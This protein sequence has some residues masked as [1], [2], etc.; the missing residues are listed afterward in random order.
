MLLKLDS[1]RS[2]RRLRIRTSCFTFTDQRVSIPAPIYLALFSPLEISSIHELLRSRLLRSS[3]RYSRFVY[4]LS[5]GDSL[6][7]LG[8]NPTRRDATRC[9]GGRE[10][11]VTV[12]R[13]LISCLL[14]VPVVTPERVVAPAVASLRECSEALS[15]DGDAV[16]HRFLRAAKERLL[17]R[18]RISRVMCVCVCVSPPSLRT[19]FSGT[20]LAFSDFS[21]AP[22]ETVPHVT[23]SSEAAA[24]TLP[25]GPPPIDSSEFID[26]PRSR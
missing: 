13:R 16:C 10:S 25:A 7:K 19:R 23:Q 24:K 15:R 14:R 22:A 20:R 11:A 2:R 26:R 4:T 17:A 9:G 1:R 3:Q 21:E 5:P 8:Q 18:G 6:R 12:F